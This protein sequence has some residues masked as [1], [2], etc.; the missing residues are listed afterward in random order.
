MFLRSTVLAAALITAPFAAT[1]SAWTLDKSHAHITFS[2]SHLG[3][4]DTQGAFREFEADITFDP[5]DISATEVSVT[6]D[7]SSVDTFWEARDAHIRRADMLDVENHPTITFV[8]TGVE[9]TGD[10]TA[11]VTGDMTLLGETREVTFDAVLNNLG[12]NPF[13]PE[14]T[15][16]GFT[17]NG[18]IDRTEFG[19]GFGAPAIGTVIPVTINIE[20]SPAG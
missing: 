16:A 10:N 19:M 8:S 12:P 13:N 3:F 1:A 11:V 14:K 2:V 5:E 18:E 15:I 6:I 20:M 9:Q 17:L 4:S 7:A